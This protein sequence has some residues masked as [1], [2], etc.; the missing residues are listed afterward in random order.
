MCRLHGVTPDEFDGTL[1]MARSFF[2]PEHLPVLERG[3]RRVIETGQF[4]EM[5]YRIRGGNGVERDV[6]ANGE[7]VCDTDGK[8]VRCF[9]TIVDVTERT[10]REAALRAQEQQ[11]AALVN[12]IDG[13]VWEADARTFQFKFVS[14]KAESILG[15]PAS[16]WIEDPAFWKNQLHEDDRESAVAHCL[17]AVR[18]GEDHDF[19]YRMRAADG[20]VVWLRDIVTVERENGETVALRGVMIDIT[21]RRRAEDEVR[22]S[23]ERFRT[24]IENVSDLIAV[25]NSDGVIRFMSPSSERVLG[26]LPE[27]LTGRSAFEW[28]HPDDAAAAAVSLG[29]A[30]AGTEKIDPVRLRLK[31]RNGSW[32]LVEALGRSVT[33]GAEEG[34]IVI[35]IRDITESANLHEQLRQ[36]QR[37][38][39][40]GTLA[41]G[42]AHDFNNI[43]AAIISFAE[44]AKMDHPDKPNL[45]EQLNQILKAGG[46][47][48]SLVRQILS[49]SRQQK[50]ELK[51]LQLGPVVLEALKM[52]RSTLPSSIELAHEIAPDLPSVRADLTQ[53]HQVVMNL[54]TNAAQALPDGCGRIRVRL[55]AV[56]ASVGGPANAVK[57]ARAPEFVRLSVTDSG[58][59]MSQGVLE[60]VFEPFFTTKGPGEG[61][62]LGLSVVHGIVRDHGG[63]VTVES[64]PGKGTSFFVLLPAVEPQMGVPAVAPD[65]APHGRGERIL[66]V[67]DEPALCES[68]GLILTRL[69][70]RP[71]IWTSPV[72]ALEAFQ[73]A[74]FDYDLLLTDLSMPAMTGTEL[75]RRA[76]A[77]RPNLPIILASGYAAAM[78][79]DAQGELGIGQ[80]LHKPLD[81][82]TLAVALARA[83]GKPS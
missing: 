34:H 10:R 60:R 52:L 65:E 25:L 73:A 20:R 44:L 74:P 31:H 48:A 5:E 14:R 36:A 55:D 57:G 24:L 69:G 76:V 54:C 22:H 3:M 82:V 64:A 32:R 15:F 13:I 30:G 38:E 23:E 79:E 46:R 26:I 9:G 33:G 83:L 81:R 7:V 63:T 66:F 17:E 12:S 39:A 47:A 53:I 68:A 28:I 56:A 16:R 70:Y 75:A 59:G 71:S 80:V 78:N 41:G 6:W 49:F 40:L 42:I 18:R 29:R 2:L 35:N 11:Y 58:R 21:D 72:K 67:D 50:Q 8:P 1:E 45:Q 51:V 27:E 4:T 19:E 77:I 61:T 62:G 43:L 37:L